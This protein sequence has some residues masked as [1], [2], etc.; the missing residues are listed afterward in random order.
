VLAPER[1]AITLAGLKLVGH[2]VSSLLKFVGENRSRPNREETSV[3]EMD[4]YRARNGRLREFPVTGQKFPALRKV[5]RVSCFR[6]F[7]REIAAVWGFVAP[8]WASGE[9]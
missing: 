3:Q 8:D 1:L 9:P 2:P 4:A 6:E 7:V 5:F